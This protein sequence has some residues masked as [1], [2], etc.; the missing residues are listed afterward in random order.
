MPSFGFIPLMVSEKKIFKHFYENWPFLPSRQP[1][2]LSDLDKSHIKHR[3]LN[4]YLF[5]RKFQIS[6]LRQKKNANLHFSHYKSMGALSCHCNQ[7]SYPTG[8][9]NN[10]S[11][12]LPID[13][14]CGIWKESASRLQRRCPL[15]MLTDNGRTPDACIYYKL[16]Y[17]P[18]A[19]V[20]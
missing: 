1:I 15:K 11:F 3:G 14:I 2:K 12:P 17:E 6:P 20:S 4:K 19:Q 8:I 5:K 13:A 9:K 16:T 7:S 18:S 10:F